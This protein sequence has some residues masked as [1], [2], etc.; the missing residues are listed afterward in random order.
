M[1]ESYKCIILQE[2]IQDAIIRVNL[3][4][5]YDYYYYY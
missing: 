1:L 3:F 2:L 5:A 4:D